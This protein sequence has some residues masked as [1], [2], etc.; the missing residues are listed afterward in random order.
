MTFTGGFATAH[1]ANI[2]LIVI[3]WLYYLHLN[4]IGIFYDPELSNFMRNHR[5]KKRVLQEM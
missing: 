4:K 1:F 3:K 2:P 5:M